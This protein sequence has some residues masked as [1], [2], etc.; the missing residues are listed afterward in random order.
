MNYHLPYVILL[1]LFSSC[2]SHDKS[3]KVSTTPN[4]PDIF[5]SGQRLAFLER[6]LWAQE[7]PNRQTFPT[8]L[9]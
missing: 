6:S 2:V 9:V 3:D 8:N 1:L 7:F 5:I 4:E